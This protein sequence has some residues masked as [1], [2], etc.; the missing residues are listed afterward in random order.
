MGGNMIYRHLTD[1]RKAILAGL[2]ALLLLF[3]SNAFAQENPACSPT[4]SSANRLTVI[5]SDLHMGVG[6]VPGTKQWNAMED[7]RWEKEF[8]LFLDEINKRGKGKTNLVINGD[9]FEL[10]Q[11]VEDNCDYGDPDL[12]CT[13]KDALKRVQ[14][15][16]AAHAPEMRVL[17]KFADSPG[18]NRVYIVPGNHDAALLY[19]GVAQ[20]LLNNINA[21]PGKVCIL[22]SG[23]WRSSDGFVYVEHG[24]QIEEGD[25]NTYKDKWPRP[26]T[27]KDGK[28]HLIRTWGERFVQK[29]YNDIENKYPII[30]NLSDEKSGF[31]YGVAARGYLL[32]ADIARLAKF[33]FFQV[34]EDQFIASLY[35]LY[36][37]PG[38]TSNVSDW[39]I[40]K[41]K[42]M[43]DDRFVSDLFSAME[44]LPLKSGV[45]TIALKRTATERKLKIKPRDLSDDE[46]IKFC[47]LRAV[48]IDDM[49]RKKENVSI[50]KCPTVQEKTLKIKKFVIGDE[51]VFKSELETYL[52]K[53]YGELSSGVRN[54]PKFKIF[55]YGHTHQAHDDKNF[56]IALPGNWFPKVF[57]SGAWIRIINPA[58][59]KILMKEQNL[60][61]K[62][63]LPEIQPEQLPSS[64]SLI[65][66][67][68]YEC[69][70]TTCEPIA[71]LCYWSLGPDKDWGFSANCELTK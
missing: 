38:D 45:N 4:E 58:Q 64:Y 10:W 18:E 71:K 21:A 55:I 42:Y 24:H 8:G 67:E 14:D 12:G 31:K 9:L 5:I 53:R 60:E 35:G 36:L 66:I 7:F 34:S 37:K 41:I 6:K 70:P 63:V 40:Q 39:D 11:F 59:L 26:F 28:T 43:N 48:L 27:V 29:Y 44:N 54:Y 1:T 23:Y 69:S 33:V 2:V 62:A 22:S 25:P 20:E 51:T 49:E 65:M 17:K 57:N 47:D 50:Q 56:N 32:P 52:P 16:L 68:P 46:I 61:D 19:K 15:V 13:E 30:D 3:D